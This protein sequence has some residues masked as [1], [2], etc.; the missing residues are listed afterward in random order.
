MTWRK[1][2]VPKKNT[3]MQAAVPADQNEIPDNHAPTYDW[4]RPLPCFLIG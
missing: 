3:L 1:A 2:S 4:V